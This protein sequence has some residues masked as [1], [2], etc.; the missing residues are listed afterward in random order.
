M[1]EARLLYRYYADALRMGPSLAQL[2]SVLRAVVHRNP[3]ARI[4]EIGGG[5]GGAT[6]HMLRAL[7]GPEQG[8]PHAASW[9][10]TD[11]SSGF[12]EARAESA[13]WSD[14]LGFDRLDIEKDPASQGSSL[15]NYDIVVACEVLHATKSMARTMA[16]VRGLMKPGGTLL[17]METIQDQVDIQFT[18]SL[19][20]GW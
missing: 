8:R 10:F 17:L 15:E 12:F 3:R 13:E 19:L 6:Q 18:F 20:A 11:I 4:F 1:I 7:G 16:H 5:T 9:R 2:A 14:I